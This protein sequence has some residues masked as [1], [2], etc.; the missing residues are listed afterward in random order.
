MV[1]ESGKGFYRRVVGTESR[2]LPAELLRPLYEILYQIAVV[3][4]V[5]EAFQRD[6]GHGEL[7]DKPLGKLPLFGRH[8]SEKP[9]N[10]LLFR[11]DFFRN[12]ELVVAFFICRHI[13]SK[14]PSAPVLPPLMCAPGSVL[15]RIEARLLTGY[16][17]RRTPG[18]MWCCDNISV[19]IESEAVGK[20]RRSLVYQCVT[21]PANCLEVILAERDCR[22]VDVPRRE[23]YLVMHDNA[24]LATMDA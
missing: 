14:P 16:L 9:F 2:G 17:F 10:F 12:R 4:F 23:L 8:F 19:C 7:I 20:R 18:G 1:C 11:L 22:V 21:R 3:D 15:P 6:G 13:M 5:G 24:G